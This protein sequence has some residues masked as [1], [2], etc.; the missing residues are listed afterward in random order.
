[1]PHVSWLA[2]VSYIAS[3]SF[4]LSRANANFISAKYAKIRVIKNYKTG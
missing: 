4:L 1:M 3:L 2:L